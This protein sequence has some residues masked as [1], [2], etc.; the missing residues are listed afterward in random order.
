MKY[1]L[2]VYHTVWIGASDAEHVHSAHHKITMTLSNYIV[3]KNVRKLHIKA[4][5]SIEF[6]H[7]S[8]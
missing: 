7:I 6:P 2:L 5:L 1:F 4:H 3:L 8:I